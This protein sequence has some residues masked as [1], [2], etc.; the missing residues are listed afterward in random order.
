MYVV[1]QTILKLGESS[2]YDIV[3][4]SFFLNV[5]KHVRGIAPLTKN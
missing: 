5:L 4:K 3:S 1:V 2:L